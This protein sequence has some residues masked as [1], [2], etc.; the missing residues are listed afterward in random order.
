[1][2]IA[3]RGVRCCIAVEPRTRELVDLQIRSS[4]HSRL[5]AS[6]TEACRCFVPSG[7]GAIAVR[8]AIAL[9]SREKSEEKR[10]LCG[11]VYTCEIRL[12]VSNPRSDGG[13]GGFV[14]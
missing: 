11:V 5:Q 14:S 6:P 2:P 10:N 12:A 9:D 13:Q 7:G 3:S 4:L 8:T 1:M